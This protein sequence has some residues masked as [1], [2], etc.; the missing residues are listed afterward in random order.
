MRVGCWKRGYYYSHGQYVGT[1]ELAQLAEVLDVED[2]DQAHRERERAGEV[3]QAERRVFQAARRQATRVDAL[4][5]AGLEAAGYHRVKRHQ[6]RRRR[7]TM[8]TRIQSQ[9]VTTATF[10]LAE[11]VQFSYVG[12]ISGKSRETRE[13]LEAKLASL[14]TQLAG[15]DPSPA[16]ELATA[17]AVHAWLD[18]WTVEMVAAHEPGKINV[19][20]ERRRTWSQ[21][22][23]L[24]AVQ[25]VERIRRLTRPRGPRVAV[26]VNNLTT[27]A[28][29]LD[30]GQRTLELAG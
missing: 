18:H 30:I 22:R 20:L 24:Q 7:E 27:Q 21:R 3:K 5:K 12:K 6:W 15:P 14:R 26:V 9:A 10:E 4:V 29:A 23:L 13:G 17:A 8:E 28:P 25:T 11:L 1:G 19:T 16:L 2:R